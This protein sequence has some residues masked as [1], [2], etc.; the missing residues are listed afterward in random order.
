MKRY[1]IIVNGHAYDVQVEEVSGDA[2]AAVA[3]PV[4][5]PAAVP[6]PAAPAAAP[7]PAATAPVPAPAPTPAPA[8]AA[9]PAAPVAVENAEVIEAPMPGNIIN[10]LVKPGQ[11]VSRG[12]VL[13]ILESMKMENEIMSPKDAVVAAVHV[14]TG[15]TV[16][17]GSPLVSLA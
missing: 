1:T 6:A 14:S 13:L 4:A 12:D 9:A 7:A 16:E 15:D 11:S 5:A 17:S 10:V 3:A 8:P 2:P